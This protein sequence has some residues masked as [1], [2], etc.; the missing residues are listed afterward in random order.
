MSQRII[1]QEA[2]TLIKWML[3]SVFPILLGIGITLLT[4]G[5][6]SKETR[7]KNRTGHKVAGIIMIVLGLIFGTF[8][9]VFGPLMLG[10]G[11]TLTT[12]GFMSAETFDEN[13]TGTLIAGS[14][15]GLIG[16]LGTGRG[17]MTIGKDSSRMY[18]KYDVAG[19]MKQM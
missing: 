3:Y 18:E 5:L 16:L 11:I 7:E 17:L 4:F 15:L 12:F 19:K 1:A 6:W 9:P 13:K 8:I 10:V 14:I 2:P